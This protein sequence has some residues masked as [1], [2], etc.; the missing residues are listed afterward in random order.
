MILLGYS[1]Y[2]ITIRDGVMSVK[3]I[4]TNQRLRPSTDR[5]H[6]ARK[7]T[8]VDDAGNKRG[9]SE[10]RIAFALKHNIPIHKI[11]KNFRFYGT[12]DN[13]IIGKRAIK[14]IA[15]DIDKLLELE[16]SLEMMKHAYYSSDYSVFLRF[17]YNNKDKAIGATS[18]RMGIAFKTL[19]QYWDYGVEIFINSLKSLTFTS[20]KPI[21]NYLCASLKYG[22]L[23]NKK[24]KFEIL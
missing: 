5:Y 17:A 11:E 24:P 20:L 21:M 7:Y 12:V 13:P 1:N 16:S 15:P 22:Y 2:D 3:N 23:R 4:R 19:E 10:L 9:L 14:N 18:K 6:N 8:L